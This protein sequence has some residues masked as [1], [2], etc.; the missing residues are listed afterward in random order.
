MLGRKI[1]TYGIWSGK[2]KT[3]LKTKQLFSNNLY[4][5]ETPDDVDFVNSSTCGR[6]TF[7]ELIKI[8]DV[9]WQLQQS[10]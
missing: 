5:C 7:K 9:C 1:L 2:T 8:C 6:K 10:Y 4:Y 3:F